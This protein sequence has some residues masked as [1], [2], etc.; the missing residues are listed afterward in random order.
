MYNSDVIYY[1]FLLN[2]LKKYMYS[3]F[4]VVALNMIA[5]LRYFGAC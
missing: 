4:L 2:F 1:G 5:M 3:V